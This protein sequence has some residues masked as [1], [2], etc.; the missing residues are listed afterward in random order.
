MERI[1]DLSA[2]TARQL[3][4]AKESY[5]REELPLYFSFTPLLENAARLLSHTE[6]SKLYENE[7]NPK[8]FDGVNYRILTNKD[9]R[10]AW[11]QFELIHPL[12]YV[13]LVNKIT[14]ENAWKLI[15]DRFSDFNNLEHI[16]CLSIPLAPSRF[17]QSNASRI[18]QWWWDVEQ[19]SIEL[20]LIYNTIYRTDI[21][22]CYGTLYTHSI[23]WALHGKDEA[24]KNRY[25][26]DL[27]GNRIDESILQMRYGQTN[28]IPQGSVLMDLIAEMVLGYA[29]CLIEKEIKR[30]RIDDYRILRYRDD[31][32]VFVN[33][34]SDGEEILKV[35]SQVM[36]GLGFRLNPE[37]TTISDDVI[38]SSI[39]LDKL[40]WM[41]RV[42]EHEKMQQCLL[43]I[44]DHSMKFPNSGS[45]HTALTEFYGN[46][47]EIRNSM[48]PNLALPIIALVTDIALR[49]P[50]VYPVSS[51][52]LSKLITFISSSQEQGD[53][54]KNIIKKLRRIP[55]IGFMELWIQRFSIAQDLDVEF[56]E[57]LC[58]VVAGEH[59]AIWNDTWILEEHR[60]EF[61]PKL[62]IDRVEFEKADPVI[63]GNEIKVFS[64]KYPE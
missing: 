6:L 54:I 21:T 55:N 60:A 5:F 20:S 38:G 48:P 64:Y 63:S 7:N 43:I 39:R 17:E 53:I 45:L 12:L 33:R 58:K 36:T 51:A 11:R 32:R 61:S 25:T 59:T 29:D 56:R 41:Y 34:S 26:N 40:E 1:L 9:G 62:M 44:R 18:R 3:L 10:Y 16:K 4:L 50:R 49:N 57:K 35:I 15:C 24:K 13:D 22:D 19:G 42:Q 47:I 8:K 28:G 37:K 31:Y 14:N 46:H 30:N 27:L 52:I 23:S 2:Q